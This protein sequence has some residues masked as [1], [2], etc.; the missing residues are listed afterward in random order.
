M[1]DMKTIARLLTAIRKAE[2]APVWSPA[3][4][5]EN[6]IQALQI[7]IDILAI[8]LQKAG[9]IDGLR[10]P[11]GPRYKVIWEISEPEITLAGIEYLE[12]ITHAGQGNG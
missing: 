10:I 5:S 1:S 3:F 8:T 6:V 9:L 11:D 2:K 4:V 12:R 7:D